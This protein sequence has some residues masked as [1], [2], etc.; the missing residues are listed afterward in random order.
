MGGVSH[1]QQLLYMAAQE[2]DLILVEGVMGL[3][4][5]IASSANLAEQ[6][7]LPVLGVIDASAMAQTFGALTYGLAHYRPQLNFFGVLANRVGSESHARML[8][9]SVPD[10]V[11]WLGALPRNADAA[12]PSRH[13]G[14]LQAQEIADLDARLDA[15]AD[16]LDNV[17]LPLPHPVRFDAAECADDSRSVPPLLAGVRIGVARD[18]AF[19][20]LYPANLDCLRSMGAEL[21]FFS[22]L[23][24]SAL[25]EVDALYLPG[26]YP[27]LH[28]QTLSANAAMR[29]A[30]QAHVAAD[31]PVLAECGGLLALLDSLS[32]KAGDTGQMFG[33]LSGTGQLTQ[34]L[35]N[36][37]M[38]SVDWGMGVVRGHSFHH[39]RVNCSLAPRFETCPERLNGHAEAVYRQNKVLASF[40]HL[41]FPSNPQAVAAVFTGEL[42]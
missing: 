20:F 31:K 4:D 10:G 8:E 21:V 13:L 15:L 37:G 17:E 36:L 33:V 34:K 40:M 16:A 5:G 3:F 22:P 14:L 38:H 11:A 24:D 41:Y 12:L 42:A 26:G 39:A 1:C 7:G 27:E 28:V 29:E 25:P 32:D 6:F 19:A 9:E 35:V 18:A 2:N 30:V 23:A